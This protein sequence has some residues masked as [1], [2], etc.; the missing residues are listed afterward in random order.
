MTD[1]TPSPAP[2]KTKK[3]V[4]CGVDKPFT[5]F[6]GRRNACNTCAAPKAPTRKGPVGYT[7]ALGRAVCELIAVGTPVH[8]IAGM[9]SMPSEREIYRWRIEHKEF[10]EMLTIAEGQR[11][12]ARVGKIE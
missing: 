3:C 2:M 7:E 10:E 8:K 1:E 6:K 11:A 5:E 12:N 4:V 9:T